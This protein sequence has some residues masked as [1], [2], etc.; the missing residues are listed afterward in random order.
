M[1]PLTWTPASPAPIPEPGRRRAL[2]ATRAGQIIAWRLDAISPDRITG[3]TVSQAHG[4][5]R[6]ANIHRGYTASDNDRGPV[7]A[8]RASGQSP[9]RLMR[10]RSAVSNHRRRQISTGHGGR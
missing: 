4:L 5:V 8:D 2:A 10:E 7:L 1:L 3:T 6:G 9:W